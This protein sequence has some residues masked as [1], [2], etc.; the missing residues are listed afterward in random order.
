VA[1]SEI[2]AHATK[3]RVRQRGRG[4]ILI[5]RSHLFG[6]ASLWIKNLW[7]KCKVQSSN[8]ENFLAK[9][10]NLDDS[11]TTLDWLDVL[12]S[13]INIDQGMSCSWN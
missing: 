5:K 13:G 3:L 7:M 6:K 4:I 10:L 2:E 8:V 1:S 11:L 9:N 12:D